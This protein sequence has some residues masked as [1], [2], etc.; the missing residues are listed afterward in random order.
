MKPT[1]VEC[2]SGGR[3]ARRTPGL[4]SAS[5]SERRIGSVLSAPLWF[6]SCLEATGVGIHKERTIPG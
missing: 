4:R 5:V 1:A 2:L 6:V 3:I